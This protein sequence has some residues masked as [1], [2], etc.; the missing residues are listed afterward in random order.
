MGMPG[1]GA[2]TFRRPDPM[3]EGQQPGQYA[4]DGEQAGQ[5]EERPEAI[6]EQDETPGGKL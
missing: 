6:G 3:G 2:R 4:E 5:Q 1:Q